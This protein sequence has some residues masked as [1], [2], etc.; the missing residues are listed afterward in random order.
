[1]VLSPQARSWACLPALHRRWLNVQ[2]RYRKR[3]FWRGHFAEVDLY[4]IPS[5][6]G[7]FMNQSLL[8]CIWMH[9]RVEIRGRILSAG[10]GFG[11]EWYASCRDLVGGR[12]KRMLIVCPLLV[13]VDSAVW[14]ERWIQTRS[15]VVMSPPT[16]TTPLKSS[17][18]WFGQRVSDAPI[19]F[20]GFHLTSHRLSVVDSFINYWYQCIP[21][22]TTQK[23]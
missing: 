2:Y 18:T 8:T 10:F 19:V 22:I 6:Y 5:V 11:F 14:Y 15:M 23:A 1:M 17:I 12:L 16:N 7:F 20:W 3:I 21:E 13:V 9:C 4:I